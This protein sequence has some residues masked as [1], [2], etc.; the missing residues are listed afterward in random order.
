[1]ASIPTSR[2]LA[3]S[4][5]VN[6]QFE[7]AS[8]TE[9]DRK[10]RGIDDYPH[11]TSDP[12]SGVT[13]DVYLGDR[14]VYYAPDTPPRSGW[15]D[16]GALPSNLRESLSGET[17]E[18]LD[19]LKAYLSGGNEAVQY[20]FSFLADMVTQTPS[21]MVGGIPAGSLPANEI[22]TDPSG[23]VFAVDPSVTGT[24]AGSMSLDLKTGEFSATWTVQQ[25][26]LTITGV[27]H[28]VADLEPP[29]SS[30][31][32]FVIPQEDAG[33]YVLTTTNI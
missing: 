8:P 2:K 5:W 21:V 3:I 22:V 32:L 1:M 29:P 7:I 33:F 24:S 16:M 26:T 23:Q 18:A 19:N 25:A 6:D 12:A 28:C 20:A 9:L 4:S 14:V 31:F 15:W 30:R 17:R 11:W 27:V 13:G 10:P